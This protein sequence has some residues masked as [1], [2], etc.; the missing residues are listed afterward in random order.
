MSDDWDDNVV[1]SVI[2]ATPISYNLRS[3]AEEDRLNEL[4]ESSG[5]TSVVFDPEPE[6]GTRS[7]V[8]TNRGGRGFNGRGSRGRGSTRGSR[9]GGH[10]SGRTQNNSNEFNETLN[11]PTRFVGKVIGMLTLML[12]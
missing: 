8:F 12:I 10:A 7:R 11:I 3:S 2:L 1:N 5:G 9:G 4:W 6:T